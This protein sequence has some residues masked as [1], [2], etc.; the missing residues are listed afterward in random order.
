MPTHNKSAYNKPAHNK[1]AHDKPT[2]ALVISSLRMGGAE[3]VA[4]FLANALVDS[5][6]I[7]LVLWSDEK[8]FFSLESQIEVVVIPAK[9]RG[10]FG[11]IERIL[12]LRR[13]FLEYKVDLV[14][15]FI[16]QTNILSILAAKMSGIAVI[17]TEHSIYESLENQKLWKALRRLVYPLANQVTTLTKRDLRNY[18]FLKRVCVMPN[19][20]A[21][22]KPVGL[23]EDFSAY[24]P[25]IL[26]AGRMIKSKHFEELL[27]VFGEFAK[28]NPQ[29]SLLLAGDGECRDSLEKEAKALGAKIVFLGQVENL[30]FAYK[31]AEFF[32]LTSHREGLS[33][34]LVESLMCGIPVV[35]YDCPYGPSEIISNNGILVKMGDKKALLKAFFEM[36]EN[37]QKFAKNTEAVY[38]RFGEEVVLKKWRE[39]IALTLQEKNQGAKED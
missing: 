28:S 9:L 13:C 8:R 21:V 31:N 37:R 17:A 29:V 10:V 20:I 1:S 39:L 36:L 2:L 23:E 27:E 34:V 25:Y 3:K 26:S 18:G 14:I 11:N 12:R 4:S 15:S 22:K 38:E 5:Y 30:Y 6:R 19:P 16:H 7:I 24:K 32:A 33:N 35:S